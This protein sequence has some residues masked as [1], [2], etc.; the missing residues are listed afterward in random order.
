MP[1]WA[2]ELAGEE[3]ELSVEELRGCVEASGE[4]PAPIGL[5]GRHAIL[6]ADC[7]CAAMAR[8]AL[9]RRAF[10][11][12]I[13]LDGLDA[14]LTDPSVIARHVEGTF[15]LSVSPGDDAP[16]GVEHLAAA[17]APGIPGRPA[18]R[19][20]DT[21][22]KVIAGAPTIVAVLR[23]SADRASF[24]ARDVMKRPFFSPVSIRAPLARTLVNLSRV[25]VGGRFADPFC[26]AGGILMEA[27]A[28]GAEAHGIDISGEMVAGAMANLGHFGLEASV[29][30]GDVSAISELAPLDAVATDPPYGRS[31]S[32]RDEGLAAIY[33]RMFESVADALR[34]G[35]HLALALPAEWA[36]HLGDEYMA[37]T[38]TFPVRVHRSLT[39]RFAVYRRE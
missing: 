13:E 19:D 28:I 34:T 14:L 2:V 10:E 20:P 37:R 27:A 35:G 11:V 24:M 33:R 23:H 8:T 6:D 12:V 31:T 3:L 22:V 18:L 36:L 38:A 21:V 32:L 5:Y 17:L 15:R 9:A 16:S 7:M 4:R 25:P 29:A 30:A 39:R 1:R 26:G